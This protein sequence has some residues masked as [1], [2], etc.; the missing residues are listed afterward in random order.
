MQKEKVK[1]AAAL[2]YKEDMTAPTVIASGQGKVADNILIEAE[3]ND[4]PVYQDEKLATILTEIEIGK[5]IP[6]ELY[7]V[8]AKIMVFVGDM[9]ELYAKT[10][11]AKK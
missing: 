1:R 4:I 3:K 7:E 6:V 9:D 5:Q 8:V 11:Y 2:S 10:K